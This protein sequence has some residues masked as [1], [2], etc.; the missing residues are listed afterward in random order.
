M[1]RKNNN[2]TDVTMIKGSVAFV[3]IATYAGQEKHL[4][5]HA[6]SDMIT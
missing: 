4:N 1:L 3:L 6:I 2:L 5:S